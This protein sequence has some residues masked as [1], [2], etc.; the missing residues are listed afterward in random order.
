MSCCGLLGRGPDLTW[1][2]EVDGLDGFGLDFFGR[3]PVYPVGTRKTGLDFT[4]A[5]VAAA[6]LSSLSFLMT[7]VRLR[8]G[9]SKVM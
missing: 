3:G 6:F 7:A 1:A 9:G 4:A 8:W 5:A 2:P